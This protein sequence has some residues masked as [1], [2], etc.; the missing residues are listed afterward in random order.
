MSLSLALYKSQVQRRLPISSTAVGQKARP[1]PPVWPTS[2]GQLC[3]VCSENAQNKQTGQ[4]L[5]E[6]WALQKEL[7]ECVRRTTRAEELLEN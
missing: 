5:G 7:E 6:K 3:A 1:A 2:V 4:I